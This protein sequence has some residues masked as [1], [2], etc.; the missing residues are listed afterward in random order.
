MTQTASKY[1]TVREIGFPLRV[2]WQEEGAW[3]VGEYVG[4]EEIPYQ[5]KMIPAN[6][7]ILKEWGTG[8]S[9]SRNGSEVEV[10]ENDTVSVAGG[11]T[12]PLASAVQGKAYRIVY[13]GKESKAKKGIAG[14]I[15]KIEEVSLA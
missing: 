1:K 9:F 7:L 4:K 12:K 14:N 8:L 15:F 13:L 10:K 5:G 3:L 11:Y 2:E 6:V